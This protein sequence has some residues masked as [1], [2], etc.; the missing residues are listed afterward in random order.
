MRMLRSKA[1]NTD[2]GHHSGNRAARREKA[3]KAAQVS[4]ALA[5]VV[6]AAIGANESLNPDKA[7]KTPA[8]AEQTVQPLA[9]AEMMAN[10]AQ[11]V[12]SFSQTHTRPSESG[13][14]VETVKLNESNGREVAFMVVKDADGIL[15]ITEQ[16]KS[17]NGASAYVAFATPF[18]KDGPMFDS[19]TLVVTQSNADPN[20]PDLIT[21]TSIVNNVVQTVS[22]NG[23]QEGTPV[24]DATTTPNDWFKA[25]YD[26]AMQ[27]LNGQPQEWLEPDTNAPAFT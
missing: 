24:V 15:Q 13:P 5:S 22:N 9:P 12:E 4:V 16:T 11:K 19:P 25:N 14:T 27:D 2:Q 7:G 23:G 8:A 26:M 21:E 10:M 20:R 6:L 3:G 18:S 1:Q 17:A